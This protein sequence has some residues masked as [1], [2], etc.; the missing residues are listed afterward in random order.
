M[1]QKEQPVE[2]EKLQKKE[3][4]RVYVPHVPF[5]QRL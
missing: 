3:E 1:V 2:D 4:V 5:P